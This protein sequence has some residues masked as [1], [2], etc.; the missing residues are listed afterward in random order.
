MEFSPT[1]QELPLSYYAFNKGINARPLEKRRRSDIVLPDS[2]YNKVVYR[3]RRAVEEIEIDLADGR[4]SII[5]RTSLPIKA[6]DVGLHI[7]EPV[8]VGDIVDHNKNLDVRAYE[9]ALQIAELIIK[10]LSLSSEND[11]DIMLNNGISIQLPDNLRKT[12]G[13]V[14]GSLREGVSQK[15]F[16]ADRKG[17]ILKRLL[18]F[19][20]EILSGA[21]GDAVKKWNVSFTT[22]DSD[23]R[24]DVSPDEM[25][26]G[27]SVNPYSFRTDGQI[28]TRIRMLGRLASFSCSAKRVTAKPA[29]SQ[30]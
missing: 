21:F 3:I 30:I 2:Q 28:T 4:K 5:N 29:D 23:R 20:E 11:I 18:K 26:L 12:I 14:Y 19:V 9:C 24:L 15:G 22:K 17:W 7:E 6:S 10:D 27:V 25:Y 16:H 13:C 1:F 8:L